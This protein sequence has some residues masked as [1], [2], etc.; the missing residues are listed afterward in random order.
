MSIQQKRLVVC[1][2]LML[3]GS[4]SVARASWLARMTCAEGGEVYATPQPEHLAASRPLEKEC[5]IQGSSVMLFPESI[6]ICERGD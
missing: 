2:W 3:R 4:C 1:M 6:F 5:W